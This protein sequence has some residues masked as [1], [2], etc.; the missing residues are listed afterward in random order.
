MLSG[1]FCGFEGGEGGDVYGDGGGDPGGEGGYA[2]SLRY[3]QVARGRAEAFLKRDEEMKTL[4]KKIDGLEK[5]R[6]GKGKEKE[7]EQEA[8]PLRERPSRA[9]LWP[10]FDQSQ[11]TGP[12]P[13]K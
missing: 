3:W 10:A 12:P 5:V 8:V 1:E 6:E 11:R 7:K 4:Q 2:V 13:G 9:R